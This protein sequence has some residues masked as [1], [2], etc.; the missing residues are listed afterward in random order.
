MSGLRIETWSMGRIARAMDG[1]LKGGQLTIEGPLGVST[2]TRKLRQGDLFV[3]LRGER[4]DGHEF[5]DAAL[6]K[7]ARGVVVDDASAATS[8]DA[9]VIVVDDCY[10]ALGALGGALFQEARQEGTQS[11]A[12]TGSNGKTTTKEILAALWKTRGEVWA[13]QGN[14]NN[15]IG[16]PLTLCAMPERCDM[17]ILE[18]GANGPGEIADLIE[19]AP[20]DQRIITSIGRAHLEGF[21]SLL[22]V[23]RAKRE[24]FQKS[25]RAT[26]AIVPVDEREYLV[27]RDFPGH[28]ITFGETSQA[29]LQVE[30][31]SVTTEGERPGMTVKIRVYGKQMEIFLPLL[32]HH[33]AHNLAAA[34]ATLVTPAETLEISPLIQA[35]RSL[36]LPG[37][38]FR[39]ERV[40][41]FEVLDD[42][43]NANPSS[44]RAS[45]AA[46]EAWLGEKPDCLSIAVIGDMLELGEEA[47]REH[48]D[49]GKWL[50]KRS[51]LTALAFVGEYAEEMAEA[52]RRT[53]TAEV[54]TFDD[55]KAVA[56]YLAGQREARIFL[57]GSRG[58]RLERIV[59][60]LKPLS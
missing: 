32:G 11:I 6:E 51:S 34:L 49:L 8:S 13:T 46:F 43:Y 26:S 1:Q 55:V 14:L 28:L 3:A 17:L 38:R 20:A 41:Q 19:I 37:G 10:R 56:N 18:M 2:D 59:D 60:S 36:T 45:F 4:F 58:N 52:A 25:E 40:G 21:G 44:M 12:L 22:G 31:S 33:N 47:L 23:R 42:A 15:H 7:G 53:T 57:K 9:A 5:V 30:A 29:D 16:L 24:I 27:S 39:I 50:A 54:M 48:R 35:L